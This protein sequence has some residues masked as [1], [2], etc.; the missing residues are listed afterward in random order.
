MQIQDYILNS[1]IKINS[2]QGIIPVVRFEVINLVPV[3]CYSSNFNLPLLSDACCSLYFCLI[4]KWGTHLDHLHFTTQISLIILILI[5]QGHA[6]S[7]SDKKLQCQ[8]SQVSLAA[9]SCQ[10]CY[11]WLIIIYPVSDKI[12]QARITGL[13][14]AAPAHTLT[15]WHHDMASWSMEM[16]D[17]WHHTLSHYASEQWYSVITP[18]LKK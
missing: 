11:L 14:Y 13:L 4:V 2:W 18:S 16:E 10:L 1:D 7:I 15:Q 5:T 17:W 8:P 6:I 3:P 12:C 9:E